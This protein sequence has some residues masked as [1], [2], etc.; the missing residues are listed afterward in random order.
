[1]KGIRLEGI[2]KVYDPGKPYEVKALRGVDAAFLPGRSYA[3]MGASGSGKSTLLNILGGLDRPSQGSYVWEDRNME[4][5]SPA[6]LTK[7]RAD[8]IG[9]ILQDYGLIEYISV[10]ENCLAP[11]VFA[12]KRR[13]VAKQEAMR[14]LD[15]LGIGELA[16]REA[17]KLSGGQKQRAAIARAIVNRPQLILADEPTGALDSRNAE[18]ILQALLSLVNQQT[19][20]ILATH[21][22]AAAQRCDH[23]LR[24]KDGR[25]AQASG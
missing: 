3:L 4:R 21:D 1:M 8:R 7:L 10:L 5:M 17:G 13:K 20:V 19:I 9:F 14:T 6:A 12:G 11:C 18:L 23:I 22:Q 25:I 16:G 15:M 24:I 2:A